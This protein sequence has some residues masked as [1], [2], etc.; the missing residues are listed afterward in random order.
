GLWSEYEIRF[1]ILSWSKSVWDQSH[2]SV[3]RGSLFR[4]RVGVPYPHTDYKFVQALGLDPDPT[5][6]ESLFYFFLSWGLELGPRFKFCMG[7]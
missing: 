4:L 6:P 2:L 1:W 5:L 7:L 3:C